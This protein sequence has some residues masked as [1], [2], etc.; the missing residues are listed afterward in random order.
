M[1]RREWGMIV[2]LACAWVLWRELDIRPGC[3]LRIH[4]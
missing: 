4:E 2:L 3:L 1:K